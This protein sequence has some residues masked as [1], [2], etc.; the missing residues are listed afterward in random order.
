MPKERFYRLPKDKA[1]TIRQ[2]AIREFKRVPPEEASINKIIQAAEISRG[3]FYTY[4]EDKDDLLG[5]L[6]GDFIEHFRQ[7]YVTGLKQNR[8]DIWDVFD[9]I[10][11]DTIRW[12]D[13]QGLVE[14][15]GNM[16]KGGSFTEQLN[17]NPE[18]ECMINTENRLHVEQVYALMDHACCPLEPDDFGELMRMQFTTLFLELKCYFSKEMSLDQV[19]ASYR[20]CIAI[21]KY[22]ACRDRSE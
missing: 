19:E 2:A 22:G 15:V 9:R 10:L 20:R 5:W 4:F 1:E 12:V 7:F 3:S 13:E 8:G 18:K 6:I 11:L 17:N 14:I 21:L 16:M